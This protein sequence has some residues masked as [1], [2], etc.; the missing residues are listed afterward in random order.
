MVWGREE[1]VSV[2]L[3]R[4]TLRQLTFKTLVGTARR[5][6]EKK[7][8]KFLRWTVLQLDPNVRDFVILDEL[9]E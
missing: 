5:K 7:I 4:M 9:K 6:N 8:L 3:C 2:F 1:T